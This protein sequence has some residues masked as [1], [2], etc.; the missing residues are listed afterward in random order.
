MVG[1]RKALSTI[2]EQGDSFVVDAP[3]GW[4]QGRTLYG[5]ITAALCAEA[6]LRRFPGLPPLRSAQ[7]AFVG[8]AAGSLRLEAQLLR[9]G[10][11]AA[12]TSVDCYSGEGLAAR[13]IFT[14]GATR[15]S[16]IDHE[17]APTP[18]VPAPEACE[19]LH[20]T[21]TPGFFQNFDI[22]LAAGDRPISGGNDPWM[23]AWVRHLDDEGVDPAVSFLALADALPPA[24]MIT[25]PEPAP[26]STMTWHVDFCQ[27]PPAEPGHWF[28]L[29]TASEHAADGYS[30]QAMDAWDSSGTRISTGHQ[31]VAIF[32]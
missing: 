14:H 12:I 18:E 21:V 8:P 30:Q 13:A 25:F 10:R 15:D 1:L 17:F 20:R 29:R 9:Q 19:S 6:S 26:I 16:K 7:F 2:A 32:G 31:T 24:A 4:T 27:Q 23:L 22:R 5:G 3:E 28:L 11:S